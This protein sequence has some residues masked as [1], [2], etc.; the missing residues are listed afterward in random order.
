MEK[1][2]GEVLRMGS[3]LGNLFERIKTFDENIKFAIMHLKKRDSKTALEIIDNLKTK[4]LGEIHNY[5]KLVAK[6]EF[7]L[8]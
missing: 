3:T 6:E 8:E 2:D 4:L 7:K 1:Y 5:A